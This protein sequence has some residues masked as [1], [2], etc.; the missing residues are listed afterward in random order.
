MCLYLVY[1]DTFGVAGVSLNRQFTAL[2][3]PSNDELWS[4]ICFYKLAHDLIC[5]L[6]RQ[7][8]KMMCIRQFSDHLRECMSEELTHHWMACRYASTYHL[9]HPDWEPFSWGRPSISRRFRVFIIR[10]Q[11]TG[12]CLM[13][14][15]V[16]L[17]AKTIRG[18]VLG[19]M[20]LRLFNMFFSIA[21]FVSMPT[22][23]YYQFV[24]RRTLFTV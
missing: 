9:I 22:K 12:V 4:R 6:D 16:I 15:F 13:T 11:L 10:L 7:L 20:R 14:V 1:E 2:S 8:L 18:V 24:V 19:V 5:L 17:T 23:I 21:I 3:D